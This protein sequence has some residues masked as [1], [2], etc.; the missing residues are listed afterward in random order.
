MGTAM[1]SSLVLV[2]AV[3]I[4]ASSSLL[5]GVSARAVC[6]DLTSYTH[7]LALSANATAAWTIEGDVVHVGVFHTGTA[8]LGFGIS[9]QGGMINGDFMIGSVGVSG[10]SQVTD[11]FATDFV[12]PS[13]DVNL[14]GEDNLFNTVYDV[15]NGCTTLTF[16]RKL[17][18]GDKYDNPIVPGR[19]NFIWAHGAPG[20]QVLSYHG[21]FRGSGC[22]DFF[23]GYD[24]ALPLDKIKLPPGFAVEIYAYS[25]KDPYFQPRELAYQE[26]TGDLYIGT[27]QGS[28]YRVNKEREISM[29]ANQLTMPNGVAIYNNTLVIAESN[30]LVMY[31]NVS[32]MTTLKEGIVLQ[33]FGPAGGTHVWK[34]IRFDKEGKLY[35][36]INS[37]C[38]T[39]LKP[40]FGRL[41]KTDLVPNAPSI[42]LAHG[43][44]DTQGF[45]FDYENNLWFTDNGRDYWG[46]LKPND[47]LNRV[48]PGNKHYGFPYCYGDH[49]VD[50]EFN[51]VGNCDAYI[52][53]KQLLAPHTAALG[54]HFYK[55]TSFPKQYQRAAFIAE[56]GSWNREP[57]FG[58]RVTN[59]FLDEDLNPISYKPF[60]DGLLTAKSEVL[61]RP[62]DVKPLPD[63]S[64]LVSDD[65][66][67]VVYRVY[68]KGE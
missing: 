10:K 45:D 40:D 38:N 39:C 23:T 30:Q 57:P 37:P 21:S 18:T 6:G 65:K 62:V 61:G 9:P 1:G 14:G 58:Y 35:Y 12:P 17:V 52:A 55:G 8:W 24:C 43:I 48:N 59:V 16:S 5:G 53:P 34:Y 3:L 64:M 36:S 51:K 56:H 2:V 11:S 66:N 27:W 29:V 41:L 15:A 54:V 60:L 67:H 50:P 32:S 13:D 44:R 19:T 31:Q 4:L 68:Y 49:D 46:N 63:G 25:P 47:E 33:K 22:V 20:V 26:T 28:V 7:T 42:E